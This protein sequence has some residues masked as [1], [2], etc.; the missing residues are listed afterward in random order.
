MH[1]IFSASELVQGQRQ[2]TV[3]EAAANPMADAPKKNAVPAEPFTV[4]WI[5][6]GCPPDLFLKIYFCPLT[7]CKVG[8][9]SP[10]RAPGPV[11]V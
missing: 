4:L 10:L 2:H 1:S 6:N 11:N 7:S 9:V 5:L 8:S 3:E